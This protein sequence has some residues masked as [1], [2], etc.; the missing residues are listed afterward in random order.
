MARM[1][2][3]NVAFILRSKRRCSFCLCDAIFSSNSTIFLW[4]LSSC[5]C[6]SQSIISVPQK[7]MKFPALAKGR[8]MI[9]TAHRVKM[10]TPQFNL[11]GASRP[12]PERCSGSPFRKGRN[13]AYL[14]PRR[15]SVLYR[16]L[17]RFFLKSSRPRH[18]P[19]PSAA[20]I[21]L[22]P[23]R[24]LPNLDSRWPWSHFS[25]NDPLTIEYDANCRAS[26]R[27]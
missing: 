14:S 25:L 12:V 3:A 9:G 18:T 7:R 2:W 17:H 21:K 20:D 27:N 1:R 13:I 16:S 19:R 4:Q 5:V 11:T 23:L 15:L 8:P 10:N 26:P 6:Q 22:K 24:V